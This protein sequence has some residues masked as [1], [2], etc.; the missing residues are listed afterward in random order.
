MKR[1][2]TVETLCAL[3]DGCYKVEFWN[4]GKRWAHRYV[5]DSNLPDVITDWIH[6]GRM[7]RP[8]VMNHQPVFA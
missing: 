5:W 3:P 1:T 8:L 7:P 4:A 2:V 6:R